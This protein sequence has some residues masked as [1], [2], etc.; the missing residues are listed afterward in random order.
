[1]FFNLLVCLYRV[2]Y[3][4]QENIH[5]QKIKV[6]ISTG[7]LQAPSSVG[8]KYKIHCKEVCSKTGMVI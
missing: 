4:I 6:I 2:T 7:S 1:M 8:N 3:K 5:K